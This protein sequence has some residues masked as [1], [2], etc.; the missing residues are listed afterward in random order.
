MPIGCTEL[1][2]R[3]DFGPLR[4]LI[5][6]DSSARFVLDELNFNLEI[7]EHTLN[8]GP[9]YGFFVV[10]STYS[11]SAIPTNQWPGSVANQL[12][13]DDST[14]AVSINFAFTVD[15]E[16][17]KSFHRDLTVDLRSVRRSVDNK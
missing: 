4:K 1:A 8:A 13:L 14:S 10:G 11:N 16:S 3:C 15:H 5:H 12:L 2:R 6:G 17:L 9:R 7:F